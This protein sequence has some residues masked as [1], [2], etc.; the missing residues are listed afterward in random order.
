MEREAAIVR[1]KLDARREMQDYPTGGEER[2]EQGLEID[3][4]CNG[5][6]VRDVRRSSL[7]SSGKR[8]ENSS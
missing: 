6:I 2:R 8:S 3:E 7:S 1:N 4:S 5:G